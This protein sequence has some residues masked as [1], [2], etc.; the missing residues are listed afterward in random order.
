MTEY[1][2]VVFSALLILIYGLFSR[3]AEKSI[4]FIGWFGTRGI[5]S[6]LYLLIALIKRGTEGYENPDQI[7]DFS[8]EL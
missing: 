1:P 3:V 7:D 5:A 6:V 8:G 2:I 4:G